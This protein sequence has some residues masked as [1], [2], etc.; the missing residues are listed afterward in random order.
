M[1]EIEIIGKKSK[2]ASK[3]L[4]NLGNKKNLALK[5]I[6]DNL[7]AN[8]DKTITSNMLD[9]ESGKISGL[10]NSFLDRLALDKSRIEAIVKSIYKIIAMEDPIGKIVSG[11]IT[12]DGLEIKRVTVPL[13]VIGLIYESRPNVTVDAACLCLKAGN[14]I[15]LRGGKEAINTNSCL[16]EIIRDSIKS[17]GLP[18]D[19]VQL[20]KDT[21][22]KSALE[23]MSLNKYLDVLI[24]R[25]SAKLIKSVT[26]NSRVPVIKTGSG[27][28]HI[29]VDKFANI[30]TAVNII[31]NAK[32]SRPSV[33]NAVETVLIHKDIA[34]KALPK[35]KDKLQTKNVELIGCHKTIKVLG[36]KVIPATDLDW[37][38]EYLDYKLAIKVVENFSD[39]I[40]HISLYSTGHS[41]CII[42]SDYNRA[43]R[44]TSLVDSA[45]VYVNA[46]TR[47]TDGGKFGLG[48][49][50]GVSTQKLHARGPMGINELTSYKFIITGDGQIR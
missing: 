24:P 15:I 26:E 28:C 10:S 38:T 39:A 11:H 18:E 7:I 19:S 35:I 14:S 25:G 47:F 44:F 31:F 17:A 49:E 41:E 46:S 21:S 16:V 4:I 30:D 9:L 36:N 27:N 12:K 32:T 33:C 20:I 48:A 1:T 34:T 2:L 22:R 50:I 3:K 23:L 43:I 40:N 6:A 42:T 8:Y 45:A 29:Y 13:G 5:N 37:S